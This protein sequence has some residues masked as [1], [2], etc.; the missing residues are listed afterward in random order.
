MCGRGENQPLGRRSKFQGMS[1]EESWDMFNNCAIHIHP[2]LKSRHVASKFHTPPMCW[3]CHKYYHIHCC[4]YSLIL[5]LK[6]Q[7]NVFKEIAHVACS[8][9]R[10][11]VLSITCQLRTI[12]PDG[13]VMQARALLNSMASTSLITAGL[14]L[15]LSRSHSDSKIIG[16]GGIVAKRWCHSFSRLHVDLHFVYILFGFIT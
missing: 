11:E 10:G 5:K 6:M 7:T 2:I 12:P 4:T 13:T 8:K 9:W 14:K 3:K 16:F 15:R 1:C